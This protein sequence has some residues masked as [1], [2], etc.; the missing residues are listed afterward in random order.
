MNVKNFLIFVIFGPLL[1]LS[2]VAGLIYYKTIVW[3][4]EGT[5]IIFEIK[6]GETFSS[7]NHSLAKQKIISSARLFHR[8]SQYKNTMTKFR[9]G[10]YLI[11]TNTNLIEV[12][13]TLLTSK[14]MSELFTVPEGKNMFEIG[15]MLED[16]QICTYAEFMALARDPSFLQTLGIEALNVEGFLYPDSYDFSTTKDPKVIIERM[17]KRFQ[18]EMKKIDLSATN[19]S[20]RELHTLASMIEKETGNGVERE[21]VSGVFYNRLKIGMRLQSDPTTIYGIFE[22]YKGNLT[23]AD[24]LEKTAYNTYAINGLP[25][26]PI[27]NPGIDSFRA[28][29]NPMKH[30]FLY[31]VSMNDGTHVFSKTYEE[32][33]KAVNNWQINSKNREGRSWRDLS[34][35]Q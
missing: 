33:L 12:H 22:R 20:F 1:G 7:I 24:L 5:E 4:Y 25:P 3:K 26:G 6:P 27:S 2:M 30:E 16:S 21:K 10:K 19:F 18:T 28:A 29:L 8:Y 15:K 14:N 32:H 17:V 11:P 34:K 9:A 35:K 23:K 31:F 13:D